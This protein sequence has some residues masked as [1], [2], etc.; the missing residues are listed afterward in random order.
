MSRMDGKVALVTG[1]ARGIGQ[2]TA[3]ELARRGAKVAIADRK[4]DLAEE[5][6]ATCR[7]ESGQ[8]AHAFMVDQGKGED[9]EA[10]VAAVV[11]HFGGIDLLFANAGTGKFSPLAEMAKKDWNLIIQV[12][13]NGTFY[14]CQEVAKAMMARGQGGKMV[15]TASSGAEVIADQL[16]AYCV[17]KAGVVMLMKHLASELGNYRI[18]VNAILPGVIETA[19]TAEKMQHPPVRN[20]LVRQTPVGR[21]GSAMDVAKLV[22]F[23]LSDDA[24]YIN[25]EGIMIDGGSTLHGYPRWYALDYTEQNKADWEEMFDQY[26]YR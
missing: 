9:V 6:A 19:I 7:K 18:N 5:T 15:L 21:W 12:N 23:L 20:M 1:G 11:E 26:P 22:A 25:G 16:G 17:A 2:E 13:L 3:L 10:C 14:F 8:D 24:G 4:L